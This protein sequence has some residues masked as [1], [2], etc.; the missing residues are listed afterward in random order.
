MRSV[1]LSK[2]TTDQLVQLFADLAVQQETP[3]QNAQLSSAPREP[4]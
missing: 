2:M 4:G 1:K 3:Q